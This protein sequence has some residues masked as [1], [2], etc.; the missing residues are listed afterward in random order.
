MFDA[1]TLAETVQENCHISDARFAGNYTLCIFLLKMREYFRWERG[2]PLSKPLPHA[3]LGKWLV[4]REEA[5]E[6]LEARDFLPLS[7][8]GHRFDPFD[9]A[10]INRRINAEGYVYSAGYGLFHKPSFF[11]ARLHRKEHRDGITLYLSH[12]ELARDLAA[13]P[14]MLQGNEVF[15]RRES[16]RRFIWE[17]IEELGHHR[18]AQS[19]MSRALACYPDGDLE[20]TLDNMTE[21][22]IGTLILH[23]SGEAMAHER[24]GHDWEELLSSL[25]RSRTEFLLR[26]VRDNLADC[27][28]TLP[29]L[30]EQDNAAALHFYFANFTGMR[31]EIFPSAVTAYHDW[32][33]SGSL[34][35]L[36]ASSEAG[37]EHW[38][39]VSQRILET[40]RSQDKPQAA[41]IET[42]CLPL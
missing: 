9:S 11:L 8:G 35:P 22:E 1:E 31:K 6:E 39:R 7:I 3:E 30:I 23:E 28:S 42:L 2:I 33:E 40:W 38:H 14:A 12:E 26:A 29:T 36:R 17:K 13:P 32:L 41:D 4:A 16:L 21:N 5:W 19:P 18:N 20:A 24:L 10:A 34:A 27:L 15:I 37:R 25:P